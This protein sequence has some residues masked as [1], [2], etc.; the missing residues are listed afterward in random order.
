MKYVESMNPYCI[1]STSLKYLAMNISSVVDCLRMPSVGWPSF[2][3]GDGS[4]ELPDN[5]LT[6]MI[7]KG[8]C[9]LKSLDIIKT[10][11]YHHP[12]NYLQK[13]WLDPS[14]EKKSID[15]QVLL[16]SHIVPWLVVIYF[17]PKTVE[18]NFLFRLHEDR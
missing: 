6:L 1:I 12:T 7:L 4:R 14:N 5:T 8:Q 18:S 2:N 11:L 10:Q 3:L 9:D 17:V 13:F 16:F 15:L